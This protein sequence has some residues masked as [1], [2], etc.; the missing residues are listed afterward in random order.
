MDVFRLHI[1][2]FLFRLYEHVVCNSEYS[3]CVPT[4]LYLHWLL[5]VRGIPS[6]LAVHGLPEGQVGQGD[7][8]HQQHPVKGKR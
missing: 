2:R 7:H 1:T 8:P 6:L 4:L 3:P 5:L